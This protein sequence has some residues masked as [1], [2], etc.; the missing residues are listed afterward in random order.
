MG[1]PI[2]F[3]DF[4]KETNTIVEDIITV[5]TEAAW[6]ETMVKESATEAKPL[7]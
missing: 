3:G 6:E 1:D 5:A 2:I 4:S 7:D